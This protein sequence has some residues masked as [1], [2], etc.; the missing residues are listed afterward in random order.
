MITVIVRYKNLVNTSKMIANACSS[1]L[2]AIKQYIAGLVVAPVAI[3][4]L[5]KNRNVE[6][7]I[8]SLNID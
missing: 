1:T 4:C 5:A 8:H 3:Q 7:V 2:A 6:T